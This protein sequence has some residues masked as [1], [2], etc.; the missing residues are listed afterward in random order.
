MQMRP[1][2]NCHVAASESV[3]AITLHRCR[4][5]LTLACDLPVWSTWLFA[6]VAEMH[7]GLYWLLSAPMVK[8]VP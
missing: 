5:T 2:R 3:T 7:V 4:I 6:P 8:G 1:D